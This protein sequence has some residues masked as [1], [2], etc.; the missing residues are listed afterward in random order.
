MPN[1]VFVTGASGFIA[2]HIV[3]QL[4]QSGHHVVGS[5]RNEQ[6]AREVL[7]AV[8]PHLEPDFDLDAALEFRALDLTQDDGWVDA[9]TGCSALIHTASPFPMA[10]PETEDDLI[11]PAVEGTLRALQAADAAG[12]RRVV[13]TS[14]A[15]AE[16]QVEPPKNRTF[17]ETDWSDPDHPTNSAYGR[18]KLKAE[19][20]AWDYVAN[21]NIA[22][23]TIN[24]VLVLGAP[25]DAHFGTS[26]A[27]IQRLLRGKD[28]MLPRIG[29]PIVDVSDVA[30]MHVAAL[31]NRETHGMRLLATAGFLWFHQIAEALAEAYP[32]RRIVT[33]VAP[34]F[35][36][37]FIARF[38]KSL[39]SILPLL[40]VMPSVSNTRARKVLGLNF[41][42][43]RD[44]VRKTAAFL[45]DTKSV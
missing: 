29:F 37:R 4:L 39:L 5:V 6:R 25:L 38:D 44:A 41:V 35:L 16:M 42:T 8:A 36:I 14:S 13:L 32:N 33:R 7:D 21:S 9:M 20:A 18:S 28:P 3:L 10:P 24:P 11:R 27:I 45:I 26:V 12:I 23:T 31:D 17:D 1:S 40:D 43:P 22:L 19:R 15:V 2:K 30:Q 34:N